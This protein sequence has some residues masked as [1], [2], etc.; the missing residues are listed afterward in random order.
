MVGFL[1]H[2]EEIIREVRES[3]VRIDLP[4]VNPDQYAADLER[5]AQMGSADAH[6]PAAAGGRP[7]RLETVPPRHPFG[8]MPS[9]D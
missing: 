2:L 4:Y 9:K 7:R 3:G 6:R 8:F 5:S 1:T